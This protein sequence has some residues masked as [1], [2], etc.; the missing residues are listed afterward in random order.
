MCASCWNLIPSSNSRKRKNSSLTDL[1]NKRSVHQ[2]ADDVSQSA[3]LIDPRST[4]HSVNP[5]EFS[6][7]HQQPRTSEDK[8]LSTQNTDS[9]LSQFNKRTKS[10]LFDRIT[11]PPSGKVI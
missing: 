2:P 3:N 10:N 6:L 4:R 5:S 1:A 9:Y 7:D 8:Q 11:L